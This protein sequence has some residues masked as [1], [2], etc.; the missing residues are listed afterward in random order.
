[1]PIACGARRVVDRALQAVA[2]RRLDLRGRRRSVRPAERLEVG[3][4]G[5]RQHER[6]AAHV[7]PA[8]GAVGGRQRELRGEAAD[9]VLSPSTAA[10]RTDRPPASACS[11]RRPPRRRRTGTASAIAHRPITIGLTARSARRPTSTTTSDASASRRPTRN[12]REKAC[13][14]ARSSSSCSPAAHRLQRR[15]HLAVGER[16]VDVGDVPV[17]LLDD[18]HDVARDADLDAGR[19]GSSRAR[20]R[21][22]TAAPGRARA[23]GRPGRSGT[24]RISPSTTPRWRARDRPAAVDRLRRAAGERGVRER[25]DGQAEPEADQH[26]R[27]QRPPR[28]RAGQQPEAR[29][30]RPRP[31]AS[32]SPASATGPR[33]P[34]RGAANAATGIADTITAASSGS[35][36]QPSTSSSTSRNSAAVSAA[37]S[38]VSAAQRRQ[39]RTS[40]GGL[41]RAGAV[42]CA[43]RDQRREGDRRLQQEDPLPAGELRERAA[44][45]R[46]DGRAGH[47]GR[48]PGARRARASP[49]RADEQLERG[50]HQRRRADGLDAARGQ[51]HVER[52]GQAA[53]RRRDAEHDDARRRRRAAGARRATYAAGTAPSARISVVRRQDARDLADLDVEPAQDVGQRERDDRRVGERRGDGEEEQRAT[54]AIAHARI[55]AAISTGGRRPRSCRRARTGSRS[56]R[57]RRCAGRG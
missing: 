21:R 31:A 3:A 51:Q 34:M 9:A 44:H 47:A 30:G 56:S 13:V 4:R 6:L 39:V 50:G 35:M 1:M 19:R 53:H 33:T 38:S 29:A 46:P 48:R 22:P 37:D 36:R 42:V 23:R 41:R 43:Q 18:P 14:A 15:R 54:D 40:G 10:P 49:S 55:F 12:E 2:H 17:G 27:R 28:R 32:R 25:R 26:L 52:P 24:S 16:P 57:R 8:G 11:R 5:E 7:Q 20:S 45:R